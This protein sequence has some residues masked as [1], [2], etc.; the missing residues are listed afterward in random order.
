MQAV[1]NYR[2]AL[3]AFGTIML[4][5]LIRSSSNASSTVS[6]SNNAHNSIIKPEIP[7]DLAPNVNILPVSAEP[8]YIT[9]EVTDK[10]NSEVADAVKEYV[11]S[12]VAIVSAAATTDVVGA[13]SASSVSSSSSSKN[14]GS[15]S[16]ESGALCTKDHQYV[17]MIDA[18]ST[19]SRVHV[20]EFD[21]CTQPPTL[22]HETFEML[23]PGLSSFDTDAVGAAKSLDPLLKVAM[24][25]I[26]E[27]FRGCTPVAVKAT[28]GLR[29]LGETKATKILGAV[30][31]HLEKDYPFA[32]VE[33]EGISMMSGDEEGVYAWITTNYLLGNIG[34]D[35]KI[36]TAAV[37]DLGGGS[38]QIVFEPTFKGNEK[39][40]DGEHK[41]ELEF[42]GES[43]DLYQFSH[44]GYGLMQGRNKVNALLV[45]NAIKEGKIVEGDVEN[46]HT[47]VSPCLPPG[48]SV[49]N[50]KVKLTSGKEYHINFKGPVTAAGPQCRFLADK[51][52]NKDAKCSQ[53]PCSFNGVH[54]PSLVKTFKETNDLYVFSYFY[55]RTRPLGMPLSF[56]LNELADLARMVCNGEEVWESVFAGIDGSVEELQKEPQWCLDLSFQVSL[57]HTGY[58]IPLHRELKTAQTIDNNEIGWCLGASLPLLEGSNWK[59]R[60]NQL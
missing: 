46:K 31:Q 18:G 19:G 9:D 34:A 11:N 59:C 24:E 14:S 58:D 45:E 50:E 40:I 21:V 43:Y 13:P 22:I 38:T 20:Y 10:G 16:S 49:S 57:L 48:T 51:V 3:C 6:T 7:Q 12:Q 53:K 23:K 29:L 17:V 35:E 32:V 5:F 33:G 1:K 2:I 8:G 52:L 36:P 60:V 42:G 26:P 55:D 37:F 39:L 28:A 15:K 56:T 54:Q 4:F 27:S 47:L 44:L 30:R 25:T 41:Y